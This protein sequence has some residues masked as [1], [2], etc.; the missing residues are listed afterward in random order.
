MAE[1][2]G[3]HER[4]VTSDQGVAGHDR[5]SNAFLIDSFS[6]EKNLPKFFR[7]LFVKSATGYVGVGWVVLFMS[8]SLLCNSLSF[9]LSFFLSLYLSFSFSLFVLLTL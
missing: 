3:T 8:F 1:D 2:R 5:S 7:P 9:F 6:V 4:A